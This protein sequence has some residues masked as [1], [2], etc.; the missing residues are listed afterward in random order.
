MPGR[1][2]PTAANSCAAGGYGVPT[3]YGRMGRREALRW[4]AGAVAVGGAALA[5]CASDG[6][7]ASQA[8]PT[9]QGN[10]IEIRFSPNVQ[11]VSW[12]KTVNELFQQFVDQNFNQNAKYKGI[13][14]TVGQP[15]QGNAAQ[16][17]TASIAGSG[18]SDIVEGCCF[19][20]PTY[21]SGDWLVPLDDYIKQSNVDVT[22][23][24]KRHMEALNAA[25]KQ[26]AIPSYDGTVAVV[27]RQ[28][29][30]DNLGLPYPDPT[31]D[32]KTALDIWTRA[33]GTDSKTQ[34]QRAG[35]SLMFSSGDYWQKLNFWLRGWGALEVDAS[36]VHCLADSPQAVECLTF[37]ADAAKNKVAIP[38]Q[39]VGALTSGAA[40]F[41]MVGEWNIFNMAQDMGTKYKWNI[42]PVPVWPSGQRSTY[43]NIDFYAI[44]RASQHQDQAWE[45]LRWLTAEPDWQRFQIQ[46]TLVSPCLVQLWAQ[47]E[48]TVKA[49]AP[50]VADKDLHWYSDAIAN[51]Y[52]WPAAFFRYSV[53]QVVNVINL[54]I[55][56]IWK[57]Q[58]SPQLG[59]RQ[60][61]DQINALEAAGPVQE[62]A[63]AAGAKK[64]PTTG[65]D[66]A[67]VPAGI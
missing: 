34:K 32:Y 30:M 49:A 17:I 10:V 56:Q 58:V 52:S 18:Y 47:W 33:S 6:T 8:A 16:Q 27:Y 26:L 3:L 38:R 20:F 64:F 54:W 15:G 29:V 7:S 51:S 40:V 46:T 4:G 23:W 5:G 61:A 45:L 66:V 22:I 12:N 25:G 44:N 11:G 13:H 37:I 42:L 41:S 67:T 35:V 50:P 19:D 53:P 55:D 31:W 2:A 39:D 65:P 24:S 62:A 60:M 36:L 21:F 14:A 57:G 59:L 9:A 28:D 48:Q 63:A 1:N 43:N